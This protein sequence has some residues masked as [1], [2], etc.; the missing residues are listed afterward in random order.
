MPM[1]LNPWA[2]VFAKTDD[3]VGL[4]RECHRLETPPPG[5]FPS[6]SPFDRYRQATRTLDRVLI[7][8]AVSTTL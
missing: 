6:V 2:I 7:E 4:Q 1:G 8:L 5:P 3:E